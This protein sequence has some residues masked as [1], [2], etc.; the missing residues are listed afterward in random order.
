MRKALWSAAACCRF[1]SGQLAGRARERGTWTGEARASSLEESASLLPLSCCP[2]CWP[3]GLAESAYS[4]ASKLAGGKRQLAAAFL[5]ASLLAVHGSAVPGP[6]R[7]EQARW[8]KAPACCRF[9][10][11][12]LA[13]RARERG[14]WTGETRASSLEES[15]SLLPLSCWPACWPPGLAESAYRDASKL[16][17]GKR[18]LAGRFPAGQ[19]AGRARERGTWTGETRASSLEES[20]SLLPLS[21]WPACWPS[22]LADST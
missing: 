15:A 2:A 14:A 13:G 11:G 18:Q 10:A 7:R 1:R 21:C 4:D 9:P 17:G 8:R 16:A 22:G 5:L 19:L 6:V 12:Q 3:P 20:A